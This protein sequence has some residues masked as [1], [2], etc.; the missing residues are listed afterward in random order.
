[1]VN[2]VKRL[3]CGIYEN[4]ENGGNITYSIF[5]PF[6]STYKIKFCEP[7]FFLLIYYHAGKFV[8][9]FYSVKTMNIW[10]DKLCLK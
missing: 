2:V 10:R 1:M 4:Q 7:S 9:D 5:S 3:N 6:L 8:V